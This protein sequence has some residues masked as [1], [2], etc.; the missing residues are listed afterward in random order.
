MNAGLASLHS[1]IIPAHMT[2]L[3]A[4]HL[5]E[6]CRVWEAARAA[7]RSSRPSGVK[8]LDCH[9]LLSYFLPLFI[10]GDTRE[11][12]LLF[13]N[14]CSLLY[15]LSLVSPSPAAPT[16]LTSSYFSS[17]T[18]FAHLHPSCLFLPSE[19]KLTSHT[20]LLLI[21]CQN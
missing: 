12:S 5:Q 16:T 21:V 13:S 3:V 17:T 9:L 10:H 18:Y 15:F 7:L 2:V 1:R 14:R 19:P 8:L 4:L 20:V 11:M 6:S